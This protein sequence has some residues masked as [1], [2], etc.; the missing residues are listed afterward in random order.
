M[1]TPQT[2]QALEILHTEENIRAYLQ[3]AKLEEAYRKRECFTE[4]KVRGNLMHKWH[5]EAITFNLYDFLVPQFKKLKGDG[6]VGLVA[7]GSWINGRSSGD[8]KEFWQE[9]ARLAEQDANR[10]KDIEKEV[11]VEIQDSQKRDQIIASMN[12]WFQGIT[13]LSIQI[14]DGGFAEGCLWNLRKNQRVN[15]YYWDSFRQIELP[16]EMIK[17]IRERKVKNEVI[18]VLGLDKFAYVDMLDST[19]QRKKEL[20]N[21]EW[22]RAGDQCRRHGSE[23]YNDASFFFSRS[24][25]DSA[26]H[27]ETDTRRYTLYERNLPQ[28]ER[29][30]EY[31]RRWKRLAQTLKVMLKGG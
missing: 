16:K 10:R 12:T 18:G 20:E 25:I 7:A 27:F 21:L 13:D 24:N 31:E 29:K 28:E 19:L 5:D 6:Y 8:N 23:L 14:Y 11:D 15:Q 1:T 30:T 4:T 17:G 26:L 3:M 9:W 2:E 22:A